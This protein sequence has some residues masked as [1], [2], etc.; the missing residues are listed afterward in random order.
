LKTVALSL[1]DGAGNTTRQRGEFVITQTGVEGSL[2]YALS[3]PARELI[4][5]Q[6]QAVLQLDLLP[7]RDAAFVQA[8]V[9]RP[10]G[11]RSLS[12]HLK[13]RLGIDGVKAGLLNEL[14]SREQFNDPLQ[15]ATAIK[16]LPLT[17]AATR[18]LDEAISSAGG[19][20]FEGLD[21]GLMLKAAPGVFCAGEMLDWEAPTGGYL[22]TAA[23]ASGRAAGRAALVYQ[24]A[25]TP[26][27]HC[28]AS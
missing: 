1:T 2:V 16:S 18:P 19:V 27:A 13:S 5:A 25:A 23:C 7:D 17:L 4:A 8:E 6:G 3:A 11:S 15:L 28:A 21:A 26:V 24:S 20:R 14:L 12:T 9:A 10:R 22:I